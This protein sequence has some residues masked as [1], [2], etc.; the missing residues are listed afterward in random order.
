MP[1]SATTPSRA[2]LVQSRDDLSG[3][4]GITKR[5]HDLIEVY[6]VKH[7]ETGLDQSLCHHGSMS[8]TS[9]D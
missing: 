8:A 9:L 5:D 3:P 7:L 4:F 6:F 1:L 2:V